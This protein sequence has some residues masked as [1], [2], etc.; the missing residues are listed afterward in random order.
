MVKSIRSK[1]ILILLI[2]SF[3]PL[4]VSRTIIYP[5]VWKAFQEA[6]IRDLESVGYKQANLVTVWMKERKYDARAFANEFLVRSFTKLSPDD[7]QFAALTSYLHF[8]ADTY[9]YKGISI[10]DAS[11]ETRVSTRDDLFGVNVSKFDYFQEAKKGKTFISD[12]RPSAFPILNEYSG[13]ERG[14]PTLLVSSPI[15]DKTN[16]I[17]GV[18]CL[19]VDVMALSREM[20]RVK[21]G[22]SGET[23]L[24]DKN[25]FMISES[26]FVSTIRRMGLVEKRTALELKL[27]DPKTR[28]LTKG[29]QA[30]LKGETGYDAEGY[31]DYRGVLV[32]GFWH[33]LPEYQWALMSEIDVE[34]AYKAL[35]DLDRDLLFISIALSLAV[36][37]GVIFIGSK[38]AAPIVHLTGVTKKMSSGDLSQRAT[39][40]SEDEIGQLAES[41]NTMT[42]IIEKKSEQLGS[43]KQYLESMFD[44]IGDIITVVDT[45]GTIQRVNQAAIN[46]YGDDVIGKNCIEVFMGKG[47]TCDGCKNLEVIENLKS[48]SHEH[49]VPTS[50]KVVFT[51]SF[52]L[53]DSEGELE[54][55]IMVSR[56]ITQKKKPSQSL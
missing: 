56:D 18:I 48:S 23:Y 50:G 29:V 27:I 21:M 3:I 14:V 9:S 12:I 35:Y 13:M 47:Q 39:V 42:R 38:I 19:R 34:E 6:R 36:V 15:S 26:R 46:Q 53:L 11:G 16:Q 17:I 40:Y 31:R 44:A 10:I 51:E 49:I 8:L 41:F 37:M 20:R 55:I 43:V 45:E 7:E 2:F 5:K 1:I 4:L 28:H 33:W 22:E 52:P 54:A 32:L 24:V 25:G 30:C